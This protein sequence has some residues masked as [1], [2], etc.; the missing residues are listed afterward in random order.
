MRLNCRQ[1]LDRDIEGRLQAELRADR[2][3]AREIF[4]S[5]AKPRWEAGVK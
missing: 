2:Q 1:P 3:Y 4:P 5:A